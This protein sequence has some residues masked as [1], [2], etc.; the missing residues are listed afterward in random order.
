MKQWVI[1]LSLLFFI[2]NFSILTSVAYAQ[3]PRIVEKE[4]FAADKIELPKNQGAHPQ[5]VKGE[6]IVKFKDKQAP[7]DIEKQVNLRKDR[8][9]SIVGRL[10]N[11]SENILLQV[12]GQKIPEEKMQE[13]IQINQQAGT[14]E[15]IEEFKNTS[16]QEDYPFGLDDIKLIKTDKTKSVEELK[17]LYES[18][19]EVEYTHPNHTYEALTTPN[20]TYYSQ[21]WGLSKLESSNAW[22]ITTGSTNVIV[23]VL[24]TGIWKEHPDLPSANIIMTPSQVYVNWDSIDF[25]GHGTHVAGTIGAA[26][27][28][29][30]GVSGINWNVKLMAVQVLDDDGI[31]SDYTIENGIK[32]AADHGVKVINLSLG[33]QNK[34]A[35]VPTTQTVIN[36]ARSKGVTVVVA[37]GN[38]NQDASNVTPASCTGVITVGATTNSDTRASY[39]NYGSIVDIAA[40]GG[41]FPPNCT[42]DTCIHS[43]GTHVDIAAEIRYYGY[44]LDAGTSMAAPHVSGVAAL[45]LAKN[46]NLTPDQIENIIKSSG[47]AIT[48]DKAIGG[49]RLNAYKALLA[50]N[51]TNTP[52]PTPTSTPTPSPTPRPTNTPTPTLTPTPTATQ[53][54]I[55]PTPTPTPI[56]GDIDGDGQATILDFNI[57]RCEF[58]GDGVCAAPPSTKTADM[59]KDGSVTILDF[60][61]WRS[62]FTQ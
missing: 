52:T 49:K 42:Q 16:Q 22:D 2:S 12:R 11:A 59:D 33:S 21:M 9:K 55:P 35:N 20:D 58:L 47:D 5:F 32:Y 39:S 17:K 15:I 38:E 24:D 23:A 37:A 13:L 1:F 3:E 14:K 7:E 53:T 36:Y 40:P 60:N 18:L 48:T 28:N 29:D 46:P 54:P 50:L 61:I 10:Q 27:N 41:Q 62:S 25:N 45:L 51:P 6:I 43:T 56:P 30:L 34:C 31:G 8:A 4:I 44:W 26:T 19:P 57:W